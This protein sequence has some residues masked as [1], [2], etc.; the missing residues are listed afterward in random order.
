MVDFTY[1]QYIEDVLSGDEI[2]CK[3]IYQA[4][5]RHKIDLRN[6]KWQWTFEEKQA[7]KAIK[8]IS[9]LK[10]TKGIWAKNKENFLLA[11]WQQFIVA[12][13]FGWIDKNTGLRRFNTAY[14]EVARKNGKTALAAAILLCVF[15][16]DKE[17]GTEIFCVA[18]KRDQ[19]KILWSQ[20]DAFVKSCPDLQKR[21]KF[22]PSTSTILVPNKFSFIKTLS[23]DSDTEDGLNPS[24]AGIDEYHAHKTNEMLEII[25]SGQAAREQPLNLIT[26]TAGFNIESPCYTEERDSGV[27]TLNKTIK[28]D[29]KFYYIAELDEKD[30]WQDL[31]NAKKANPNLGI[32][33]SE[34]YIKERI[35][36]AS[37]IVSKQSLIL[38]KNLNMWVD[39]PETWI[40]MNDWKKLAMD[41]SFS[42]LQNCRC[43]I[44]VDLS[45]KIDLSCAVFEL[46]PDNYDWPI[47]IPRFYMP[48]EIVKEK[49]RND[50]VPYDV[51]AKQGWISLTPGNVIDQDFIEK[52]I[53]RI[54]QDNNLDLEN[55]AYDPW[56][57]T[58]LIANLQESGINCIEF[59]QGFA[60]M[61]MPSKNFEADIIS[62]KLFHDGNPILQWNISCVQLEID[63]ADNIKPSKRKIRKSSK[64]IDGVIGAIEAHAMGVTG[65]VV[66]TID[67]GTLYII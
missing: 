23:S 18:T 11:P 22:Y 58:Q 1:N 47:I 41:I 33:V 63:P 66:D 45:N 39:A 40:K 65:K 50:H 20:M 8:F 32:S 55:L 15:F 46:Y 49:S 13:L 35:K 52:D 14:I 16:L 21:V 19:A 59:R 64:R 27:N 24:A 5:K 6:R 56:N 12:S 57:A 48:E 31:K 44:G 54:I 60:S 67:D 28:N 17:P 53:L 9:L 43:N 25:Q 10:H 61:S 7:Q 38:T 30:D 29:R 3:F 42:D 34:D 4:V 26:T 2:T 37:E 36:E 62:Q 51:W